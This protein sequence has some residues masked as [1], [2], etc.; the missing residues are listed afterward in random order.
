MCCPKTLL[1]FK[2]YF[3]TVTEF[4]V[5]KFKFKQLRILFHKRVTRKW[6]LFV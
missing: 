5:V 3:P 6:D 4:K 1:N 2:N